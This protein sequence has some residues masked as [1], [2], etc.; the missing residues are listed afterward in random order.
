SMDQKN[1][2]LLETLKQRQEQYLKA[3]YAFKDTDY[4]RAKDF[5]AS[6]KSIQNATLSLL[7]EGQ[8]PVGFVMPEE[9][10]LSQQKKT[11][12]PNHA[13]VT[14]KKK[15]QVNATPTSTPK[16]KIVTAIDNA[17]ETHIVNEDITSLTTLSKEDQ[18]VKLISELE[19]QI[20]LCTTISAYYLKSGNKNLATT[21]L[22]YKKAFSADLTSLKSYQNHNKDIPP[23]HFRDVS[24]NVENAFFE[25]SANDMEVCIERAWNLG[26]KEVN[27]KD[28]DAYVNWD[29]GWPTEGNP[30][31]G[32][33]KGDTSV[34]KRG[35]DPEFSYKKIISIERTK[36]FQR[37]ID[38]KKATFEVFHYRGFL[39][40][41]I[42][43]GKAQVKLDSL[44]RKAEIHEVLDLVDANRRPTGGKLEIRLRLR[45]P[46]V[47]AD[48]VQKTEKWLIIHGFNTNNPKTNTQASA[49]SLEATPAKSTSQSATSPKTQTSASSI[50]VTPAKSTSQ[51]D[52]PP[53]NTEVNDLDPAKS[54]SQPDPPPSN[55]EVNDLDPAKSTSRPDPPP[56]NTEVND[57]DPAKSTS[58]PDPPPSNTEVNELDLAEEQLNNADLIVSTGLIQEEIELLNS[59]ILTL[60]AQGKPVPDDLFDRKSAL[61]IKMSLMEIQVQTG[62]LTIDQYLDQVKA[63]IAD[64]KRLALIFK[65]AGKIEEAKKA[66]VKCKVMENEVKQ[67]EEAMASVE[68][69]FVAE[70]KRPSRKSDAVENHL[71]KHQKRQA[72]LSREEVA[73]LNRG[74]RHR[75]SED[76]FLDNEVVSTSY[77][78]KRWKVNEEGIELLK[79]ERRRIL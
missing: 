2:E 77:L 63:S 50:E 71:K 45:V 74:K 18:Y 22:Q 76:S 14:P 42:S 39:R 67:M 24:Y 8:L 57:L 13:Q 61:E 25:L 55:T 33:G 51:P 46:L 34:A 7:K 17:T 26:N 3:V 1:K 66:L 19:E 65:K 73:T 10:N 49:S 56:S 68:A 32:S 21:F 43:L 78:S 75:S 41:A 31:A 9:P 62:Q 29:I 72:K 60:E 53:L 27:G 64:F 58:R 59:Q 16:K 70:N 36:S 11:R 30:G 79:S 12:A 54:T 52:P 40:R 6:A 35:M 23:F 5:M 48:V 37:Y 47:G 15:T 28:V 20:S 44:S 4:L 38:R 69:N